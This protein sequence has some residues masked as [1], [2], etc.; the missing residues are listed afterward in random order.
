MGQRYPELEELLEGQDPERL[1]VVHRSLW[2]ILSNLVLFFIL[3]ALVYLVIL[4]FGD[5]RLPQNIPVLRHVSLR[6]LAVI[7]V[8]ALLEIVRRYHDNLYV[9]GSDTVSHFAG[10]LSLNSSLP[11]L[12]YTDIVTVGVKQDILGRIFDYGNVLLDSAGESRVELTMTGVR[13]PREVVRLVEGFRKHSLEQ[14]G[15]TTT[16]H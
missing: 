13:S 8:L 1:L 7:P 3:T 14:G 16:R 2:S 4:A 5:V 12:K 10:R 11:S 9:L 15:V 6:W